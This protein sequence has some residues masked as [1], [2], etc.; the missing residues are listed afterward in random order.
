M[1]KRIDSREALFELLNGNEK[2]YIKG[3]DA[4]LR[5]LDR[6]WSFHEF[7]EGRYFNETQFFIEIEDNEDI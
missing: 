1:L 6:T 7:G 4:Y 5:A 2:V 3:I